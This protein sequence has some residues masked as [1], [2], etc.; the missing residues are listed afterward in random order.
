MVYNVLRGYYST[1]MSMV[2]HI[3]RWAGDG[4][5]GPAQKFWFSWLSAAF[6]K[7]ARRSTRFEFLNFFLLFDD[8]NAIQF[9]RLLAW[10]Q[11]PF[12]HAHAVDSI[13]W[14]Y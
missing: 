1:H 12:G 4:S 10:E 9:S 3:R 6:R 8:A 13:P 14:Y 11:A 2:M 7:G 5:N